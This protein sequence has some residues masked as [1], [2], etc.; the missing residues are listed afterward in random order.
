[1][2]ERQDQR[3]ELIKMRAAMIKVQGQDTVVTN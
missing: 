3:K 1:M 2:E